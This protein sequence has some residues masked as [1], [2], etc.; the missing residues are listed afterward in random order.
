MLYLITLLSCITST[1]EIV[2][3][4]HNHTLLASLPHVKSRMLRLITLSLHHF[5]MWNCA[6]WASS[7]TT[8]ITSTCEIMHVAPSSHCI[9][10]TSTCEI[11]HVEPNHTL[12]A[13]LPYVKSCMLRTHNTLSCITSICEIM[14]HHTLLASFPHVKSCMLRLITLNL[15]NFHMWNHAP[16]HTTCITSTCEIHACCASSHSICITSKC[17]IMHHHTLLASLPHVKLCMLRLITL[18][19]HNFQMWNHAP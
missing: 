16:S 7:H 17:E 5:H 13:S 8:C 1:C 14:H 2:H 12:L 19:L 9:C 11:V 6:C 15:H 4:E 10:I 3:I 18:N